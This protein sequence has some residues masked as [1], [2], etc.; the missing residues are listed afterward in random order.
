ML[1][2]RV[3]KKPVASVAEFKAAIKGESFKEGVMLLVRT[4]EGNRFVVLQQ[5]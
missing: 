5:S 1:I 3:G 2:L 4:Q